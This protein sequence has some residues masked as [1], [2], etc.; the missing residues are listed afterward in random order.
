VPKEV[1]YWLSLSLLL[2]L[3]GCGTLANTFEDEP[4][5]KIY[6]GVRQDFTG[7]TFAHGGFIDWPF[8]LVLDTI[9]LPYT[10]PVTI[11]NY[12]TEGEAELGPDGGGVKGEEPG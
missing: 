10:I 11:H 8:S 1:Q 5:N 2:A 4:K 3:S 7:W 12:A 9:L 6:V